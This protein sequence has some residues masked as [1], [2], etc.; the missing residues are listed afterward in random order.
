[1]K[2][3]TAILLSVLLVIPA[4]LSP[5]PAFA[6][7]AGDEAYVSG[8]SVSSVIDGT[9]SFDDDDE[10]GNDSS[11]SNHII[12][13]Y[14]TLKYT[15]SYTTKMKSDASV[16]SLDSAK[17]YV[18]FELPVDSAKATFDTDSMKWLQDPVL[19]EN[20][21]SVVLTGYRLLEKGSASAAVPNS[22]TLSVIIS[23]KNMKNGDVLSPAFHAWLDNG[24][25]SDIP[26]EGRSIVCDKASGN[27]A[28]VK[29]SAAPKYNLRLHRNSYSDT[30]GDFDFETGQSVDSGIH[31]SLAGFGVAVTIQNDEDKGLKGI[32]MPEGKV[33]FEMDFEIW[34]QGESES[35]STVVTDRSYPLLWDYKHNE[36]SGEKGFLGR[37]MDWGGY[38]TKFDMEFPYS[39]LGSHHPRNSCIDSGDFTV[40]QNPVTKKIT[41][42][43][44]NFKIGDTFPT[45]AALGSSSSSPKFSDNIGFFS[46][47]F[48]QLIFPH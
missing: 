40:T 33:S 31:G 26:G 32:E 17:L 39:I 18:R 7:A 22:G 3:I 15:L 34:Q 25:N 8:F 5:L 14:D 46:V 38:S 19:T 16:S 36:M 13:T 30:E 44:E 11:A 42:T 9:E 28:A 48:I 24:D 4:M 29:I 2:K 1:M 41:I 45:H 35:E 47:G 27:D 37:Q 21:D 6:K 20:E 23:V 43:F 10:P 12:R